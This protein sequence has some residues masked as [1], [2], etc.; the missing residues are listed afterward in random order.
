MI[1][2]GMV[3]PLA[4]WCDT[5]GPWPIRRRPMKRVITTDYVARL[6]Q[7]VKG[8]MWA[9]DIEESLA[10]ERKYLPKVIKILSRPRKQ[11][12]SGS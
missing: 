5:S 4:A 8:E 3:G 2:P 11:I 12:S 10:L 6:F 1:R 7:E 9:K